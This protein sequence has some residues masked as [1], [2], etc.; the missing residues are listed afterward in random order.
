MRGEEDLLAEVCHEVRGDGGAQGVAPHHQPA[1]H[2]GLLTG[3]GP[4]LASSQS[5]TALASA[6]TPP[7]VGDTCLEESAYLGT[8]SIRGAKCN[9]LSISS[10]FQRVCTFCYI[11]RRRKIQTFKEC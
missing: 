7:S 2:L 6:T 9:F 5:Y 8:A 4:T 10:W 3:R 11:F 1:A